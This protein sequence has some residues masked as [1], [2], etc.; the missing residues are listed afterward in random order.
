VAA[1]MLVVA[2]SRAEEAGSLNQTVAG[3]EIYLG[4]VPA[5]MVRGHP[6]QHPERRMHDGTT[7]RGYHVMVALFETK[8]GARITDAQVG[9]RL[10]S[11]SPSG[12]E[13]RLEP[14][15][16]A[17]AQTY[18]HYFDMVP[19]GSYRIDVSIRRPGIAEPIRATFHWMAR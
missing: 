13:T 1:L 11:P 6:R 9:A 2:P 16:I 14:M 7:G 10:A 3:V 18:G 12:P 8:T 19:G 17:G 4:V 5:A 15:T